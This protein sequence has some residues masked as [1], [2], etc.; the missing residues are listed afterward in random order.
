MKFAASGVENANAAIV[1]AEN[2]VAA[3]HAQLQAG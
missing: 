1:A 3:A 2:Q